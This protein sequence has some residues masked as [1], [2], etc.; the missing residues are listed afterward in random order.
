VA[1]NPDPAIPKAYPEPID[2]VLTAVEKPK[3]IKKIFVDERFS[4]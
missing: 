3:K 2:L 1:I 4:R